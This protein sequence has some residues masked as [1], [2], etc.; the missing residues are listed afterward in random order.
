MKH[1]YFPTHSVEH[2]AESSDVDQFKNI[3]LKIK[4]KIKK[5]K[6]GTHSSTQFLACQLHLVCI[7]A[8]GFILIVDTHYC[9]AMS[10]K[11]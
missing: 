1:K 8:L 5:R 9:I 11:Q 3:E 2:S 10:P 6:K 4:H 7:E